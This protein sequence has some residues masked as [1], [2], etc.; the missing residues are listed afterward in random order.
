[1][2][3][4]NAMAI[5]CISS[6]PSPAGISEIT[7]KDSGSQKS[8]QM[9]KV[10]LTPSTQYLWSF[11]KY[12]RLLFHLLRSSSTGILLA[13]P[14]TW[15][16]GPKAVSHTMDTALNEDVRKNQICH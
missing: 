13:V 6:K 5:F 10:P 12:V 4:R 1:M 9:L 8:I 3:C 2:T 15:R 11:L 14:F 16:I 7:G